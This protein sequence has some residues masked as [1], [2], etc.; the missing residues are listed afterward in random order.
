MPHIRSRA[1]R[2]LPRRWRV[3]SVVGAFVVAGGLTWGLASAAG[4]IPDANGVIHGCFL[5]PTG[6]VRIVTSAADCRT[7]ETAIQ[8]NQKGPQGLTGARGVA[9]PQGLRGATGATG[10]AGPQGPKGDTGAQGP[11]GPAGNGVPGTARVL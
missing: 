2:I 6:S 10:A 5:P 1:N 7:G 8:W 11:P 4:T 3:A 9:G